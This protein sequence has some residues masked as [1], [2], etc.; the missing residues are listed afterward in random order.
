MQASPVKNVMCFEFG[1]LLDLFDRAVL[2]FARQLFFAGRQQE[3]TLP[4][5]YTV[6]VRLQVNLQLLPHLRKTHTHTYMFIKWYTNTQ[7]IF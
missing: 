4:C 7:I 2:Q 6:G 3:I 1:P 5:G